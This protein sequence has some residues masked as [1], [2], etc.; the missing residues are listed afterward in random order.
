MPLRSTGTTDARSESS[1]SYAPA[2]A[3]ASSRAGCAPGG[4]VHRAERALPRVVGGG[5]DLP[6]PGWSDTDVRFAFLAAVGEESPALA[7]L[8]ESHADAIAVLAE[9]GH[10]APPNALLGVWAAEP[11]EVRLVATPRGD[12]WRLYGVLR[13]ATAASV[14]THALVGARA[15]DERLLFLLDVPRTTRLVSRLGLWTTVAVDADLEE[16][17]R[18][19]GHDAYHARP[20]FWH[21]VAGVASCWL[22]AA[23]GLTGGAGAPSVATAISR[24]SRLVEEAACAID[25]EP[26][27]SH[28]D[29]AVH[30]RAAARAAAV[31]AVGHHGRTSDSRRARRAIELATLI[32]RERRGYAVSSRSRTLN[33]RRQSSS[34]S[35]SIESRHS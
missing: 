30:A 15:G 22:G 27:G 19:G 34:V 20:G 6:L 31:S 25:W 8:V 14:L 9:L 5:I 3:L 11:D 29:R 32:R 12:R 21:H 13:S 10:P 26:G 18:V 7:R 24:A 28:E 2:T 1:F 4:L 35:P 16:A 23:R 33:G 17:A